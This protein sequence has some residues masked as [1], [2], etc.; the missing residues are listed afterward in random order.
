MT[1]FINNLKDPIEWLPRES[2]HVVVFSLLLEYFPAPYQRWISC[3][4]AHELLMYNGILVIVTP[5][6]S[7]Q[8]RN[9]S[10][11]KSWKIAIESL[12]FKRW[13][14]IKQ[15]HIHCMVFRKIELTDKDKQ[16]S[17]L[18]GITPDMIYI[19]Q[20]FHNVPNNCS[21]SDDDATSPYSYEDEQFYREHI[22]HE[23]PVLSSESDD[24]D[25]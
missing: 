15:E 9:A 7:H 5:D 16:E 11:M 20:D 1:T 23:L 6:S 14:Y 10:Q 18:K 24:V 12:G 25:D 21:A 4:R 17:F 19:P 3:Q 8:N 22:L 13:R 2:F